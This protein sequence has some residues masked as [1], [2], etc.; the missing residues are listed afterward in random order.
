MNANTVAQ[1]SHLTRGHKPSGCTVLVVG[2]G[3]AG[4][5]AARNLRA[6][7]WTV[8]VLE[9]RNRIG[10]RVWT[11][12]SWQ[13]VSLDRGAS[14]ING[15]IGNPLFRLVQ[16][17]DLAAVTTGYHSSPVIYTS[18]GEVVPKAE[19]AVAQTRFARI[20][21]SLGQKR[22]ALY[23]DLPLSQAFDRA[24]SDLSFST[25]QLHL[26][27]LFHTVIEQEYA[28]DGSDLS[29]WHWD[30]V[31]GYRGDDVILPAGLS[32]LIERLAQGLDIKP[33]HIVRRVEYNSRGVKIETDKAVFRAAYAI[34]TLPLG[35]LKNGSVEFSAGL[36]RRKRASIEKLKMGV[37]NKIF[38]RFP[39]CFWPKHCDWLEYMDEQPV[40]W[41]V[42]FNSFK[43][44]KVPVL[45]GFD[46]GAHERSLEHL[47]DHEIVSTAMNVLHRIFG[48]EI[49]APIGW[50]TT[51]WAS[52]PFSFGSYSHTPPG[53]S[54]LDY[55]MLA[56]PI[57]GRL[58]FAG[59]AT[60]R[61]HY[62]TVHGAFLSGVRAARQIQTI[63]R[64]ATRAPSARTAPSRRSAANRS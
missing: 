7:G 16:S 45:V 38:L 12:G 2:A 11:E 51:R 50:H 33:S 39:R 21:A 9:A 53:A 47:S 62:G 13:D 1:R 19:Q 31:G 5:V 55:D 52:D 40:H 44:T 42:W 54:S 24:C 35:V 25:S 23:R 4:V 36:P 3:I 56:Q 60:H 22:Q 59:E 29:L 26:K 58:F 18:K 37:L 46:I 10:G 14:W 8:I 6:Q 43:Y 15:T 61:S 27:H 41:A 28:A 17:F 32:Q 57:G 49:P 48:S 63:N 34:I 30:E 20:M 64:T